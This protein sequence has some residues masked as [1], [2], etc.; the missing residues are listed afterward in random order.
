MKQIYLIHAH[1]HLEYLNYLIDCLSGP[2]SVVYVNIDKKSAIDCHK[3]N[4]KAVQVKERVSINWGGWSQCEATIN[5][6]RQI[7]AEQAQYGH[8]IFLSGQDL[9]VYTTAE[10][11]RRLQAGQQY[12]DYNSIDE[13]WPEVKKRVGHF[14]RSELT[15]LYIRRKGLAGLAGKVLYKSVYYLVNGAYRIF[16][17][18]W[19][20]LPLGLK[21]YG[22]SQWWMLDQDCINYILH[23]IDQHPELIR[24]FRTTFCADELF[25]QTIILNS[26]FR[27]QVKPILRYIDW[28]NSPDGKS[29]KV[30]D[31]ED[32]EAIKTSGA[33][34][35]RKVDPVK[36]LALINHMAHEN[37]WPR[38]NADQI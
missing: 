38:F 25:F 26:A 17:G 16:K 34:L 21:A 32:Y 11:A 36:S 5:S 20:V 1:N 13:D 4:P 29:P 15:R 23:Y 37:N 35:C 28:A 31:Q 27:D 19:R 9:P 7:N 3:I 22:G 12:I 18:R 2:Q 10:I 33:L 8:I 14:H 30:L 24:F 6:L